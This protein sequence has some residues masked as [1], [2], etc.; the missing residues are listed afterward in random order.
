[1]ARAQG[2]RVRI[3]SAPPATPQF[4]RTSCCRWKGPTCPRV[5]TGDAA[6]ARSLAVSLASA[7]S[8]RLGVSGRRIYLRRGRKV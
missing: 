8:L 2:L 3:P 1:M 7:A 6:W 4:W 5:V